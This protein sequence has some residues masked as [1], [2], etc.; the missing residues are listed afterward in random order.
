MTEKLKQLIKEEMVN[1]QKESQEVINAFDWIKISEEIGK[2]YL[3]DENEINDL[4][5]ETSLILLG[6]NNVD[7][8]APNIENNV[9]TS[10]NEAEKI[11]KEVNEKI[12]EPI[13]DILAKNIKEKLKTKDPTWKQTLDFILSGGNYSVFI[14][15]EE[16]Q[17]TPTPETSKTTTLDNGSKITDIKNKFVI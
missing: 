7:E 13:Y 10:K 2:K 4:Q 11:S 5:A 17:N 6:I 16:N 3:L 12:F 1:L 9:G 8:Y 14:K 15:R